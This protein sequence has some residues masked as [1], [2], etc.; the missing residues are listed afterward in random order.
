MQVKCIIFFLSLHYSTHYLSYFASQGTALQSFFNLRAADGWI[1]D[2]ADLPLTYKFG[3]IRPNGESC[4]LGSATQ[5]NEATVSLPAGDPRQ[6]FR[7]PVFVEVSDNKGSRTRASRFLTV[8]PIDRLSHHAI[9]SFATRL[10]PAFEAKDASSFIGEV[11][12]LVTELNEQ[13]SPGL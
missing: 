3:Y 12:P 1:D 5:A 6:K 11:A 13:G 2:E 9:L 10:D 7:L 4:F 8:R